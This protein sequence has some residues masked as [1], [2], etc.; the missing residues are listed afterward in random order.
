[1]RLK[2]SGF[3]LVELLVG[4]RDHRHPRRLAFAGR[5]SSARSGSADAVLE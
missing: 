3:T 2:K 5:A 1:M 4:H